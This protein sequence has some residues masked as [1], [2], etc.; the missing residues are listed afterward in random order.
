MPHEPFLHISVLR[1]DVVELLQPRPGALFVDGTLGGGG[2]AE[3]LLLAG[4]RLVG[5]DRD[6]DAL[7]AAGARLAPFGDRAELHHA[8]FADLPRIL[9]H[10]RADAIL[11]DLGVSSPQ[12]DRPE[13]GFSFQHDGPVDF[14]MDPSSGEPL[15]ARL[16]AVTEAELADVL[17]RYG[18][19]RDARRVAR[20]IV[21]GRPFRGTLHLASVIASA[22]RGAR[23]S[24]INPATRSFQGLRIW[25]NDELGQ[26]DAA[27]AAFPAL[28][29]PGG[30]FGVISFHSLEDRPV[31]QAFRHLAGED[32]PKDLRGNPITPPLYAHVERRGRVEGP[33]SANP[34]A[35]SARLRVLERLP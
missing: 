19:E 15:S 33:E 4:V 20:V 23:A 10:R 32:A 28:L 24:R 8:P 29:A 34:R 22:V 9:G 1:D 7:A 2:H 12:I 13:R 21:A 17:W 3:A 26:L 30:R 5:L 27:L 25:V 16:D 6:P 11:L 18:E 14:R 35:R 31:K